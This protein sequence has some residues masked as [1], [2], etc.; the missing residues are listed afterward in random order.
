MNRDTTKVYGPLKPSGPQAAVAIAL[1]EMHD[2]FKDRPAATV[3]EKAT[4]V[5]RR[6]RELR[7]LPPKLEEW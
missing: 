2:H 1:R 7:G 5:E 4:W 6:V 3:T